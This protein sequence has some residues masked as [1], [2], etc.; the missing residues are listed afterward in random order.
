ML[1]RGMVSGP[2]AERG[3]W[4]TVKTSVET[5][6]SKMKELQLSLDMQILFLE[7]IK[8]SIL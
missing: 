8:M 6:L 1:Y 5:L 2:E 7:K 4:L 3:L